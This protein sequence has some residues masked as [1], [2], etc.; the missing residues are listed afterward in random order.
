M[1][2]TSLGSGLNRPKLKTVAQSATIATEKKGTIP[3]KMKDKTDDYKAIDW[4]FP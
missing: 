4:D 1:L 2:L 3:L